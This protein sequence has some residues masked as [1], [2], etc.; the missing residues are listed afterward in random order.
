MRKKLDEFALKYNEEVL[1]IPNNT[2]SM[3]MTLKNLF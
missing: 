1:K 3:G 2:I